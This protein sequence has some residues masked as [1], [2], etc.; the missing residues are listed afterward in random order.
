MLKGQNSD[1][2]SLD[3]LM[4]DR[5]RGRFRSVS[6][7]KAL[8]AITRMPLLKRQVGPGIEPSQ[9]DM[10]PRCRDDRGTSLYRS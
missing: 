4:A 1:F 3:R 7:M 2:R 9:V 5:V 10:Q 6:V 8:E